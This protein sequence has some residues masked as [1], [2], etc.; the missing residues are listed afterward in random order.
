MG[1]RF[2]VLASGSSGNSSLVETNSYGVLLDVGLG[3]RTLASRL[4]V[5]GASWADV[6][7]VL[8]THTHGDHWNENTL[9]HLARRRIPLCCHRAHAALLQ[10]VPAF[11]DLQTQGLV[12]EYV[13]NEEMEFARGFLA[14]AI[15]V[16][17][18]GG[19]TFGFRLTATADIFGNTCSLGY[20]ADLGSWDH[21]L[22]QELADVELLALE[23]NHDVAMQ[24]SSG[25]HPQ[26]I[27]RVLGDDGHLSNEQAAALLREVIARS[28]PARL[29][30]LVQLHLSRQCNRPTLALETARQALE[31]LCIEAEIHTAS[32]D[33]AGRTLRLGEASARRPQRRAKVDSLERRTAATGRPSGP[34]LPGMDDT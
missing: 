23:F 14:K 32:Q 3:P 21:A 24:L 13:A 34:S 9:A 22:A 19:E 28:S 26:L 4:A 20:A 16:R 29:R 12:R 25:R 2:T 1:L 15:P 10:D 5:V 33:Q 6:H 30:C 11:A 27:T 7:A 31:D 17:H 8:L 18:D